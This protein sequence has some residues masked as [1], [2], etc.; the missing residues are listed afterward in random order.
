MIEVHDLVVLAEARWPEPGDG[1]PPG[2]P[3]FV[4]SA[5][6]PLAA[7]AAERCLER[8]GLLTG[9]TGVVVVTAGDR[10]SAD[11]VERLVAQGKRVGPLFFFQSVPNSIAGWIAAKWDL[12]GP[13]VCVTDGGFDE[14]A[15]LIGDGDA[16]RVLIVQV[17]AD[18][19]SAQIVSGGES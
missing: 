6:N 5:F 7:A 19:A 11:A 8:A 16:D 10:V 17:A 4:E 3:G 15:L 14:A 9:T 13:V 2:I 18:E 1:V 12:R